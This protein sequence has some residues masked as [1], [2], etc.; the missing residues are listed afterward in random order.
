[1]GESSPPGHLL[2]CSL[3]HTE[4]PAPTHAV[5]EE[6]P[7]APRLSDAH[8]SP[9]AHRAPANRAR[10]DVAVAWMAAYL[11]VTSF[12]SDVCPAADESFSLGRVRDGT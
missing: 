2:S 9:Q 6:T 7:L 10:M 8:G 5:V 4:R 1:M 3:H 11:S 12:D